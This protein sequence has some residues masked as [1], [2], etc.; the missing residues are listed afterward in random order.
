MKKEKI[1]IKTIV[2]YIRDFSIVVAGIAVTMYVNDLI[3]CKSEKR[4][5]KLYLDAVML[6]LEDNIRELENQI[7]T[8]QKSIRYV[9]Y[10]NTVGPKSSADIRVVNR[11]SIISYIDAIYYIQSTTY[12]NYAFE[13]FKQSGTMRLMDNKELLLSIWKAYTYLDEVKDIIA[14]GYQF[15]F[16]E[17]KRE[18]HLLP[19]E[20]QKNIPMYT[21]YTQTG[22]TLEF[23]RLW[24]ESA[25][26][27]KETIKK[28]ERK[29]ENQN[30]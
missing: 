21:F 2:R 9:N 1:S 30:K 14:M 22:W 12:K 23:Q 4:D 5:L 24:K 20:R 13:M 15:K 26:M 7:T 11:D 6:E 18:L 16:E 17:V 19:E 25:E 8:E 3:T 29:H 10:L 27:L 28:I